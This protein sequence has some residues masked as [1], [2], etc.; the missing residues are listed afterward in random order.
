MAERPLPTCQDNQ[1]IH[2]ASGTAEARTVVTA[3]SAS[4]V[5]E[6]P[7]GQ[8]EGEEQVDVLG[9]SGCGE[10]D[11]HPDCPS[12]QREAHGQRRQCY[13]QRICGG[14]LYG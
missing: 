10:G 2:N 7:S 14:Q 9:E 11:H 1:P 6:H 4:P 3:S 5:E 8:S 13:R 12:A